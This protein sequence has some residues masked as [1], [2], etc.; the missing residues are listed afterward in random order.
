MDLFCANISLRRILFVSF[1]KTHA[2]YAVLEGFSRIF[3]NYSM[4]HSFYF[5][6]RE[7]M[8]FANYP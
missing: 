2:G 7:F 1:V 5:T 8:P 3:N 6:Q 4:T